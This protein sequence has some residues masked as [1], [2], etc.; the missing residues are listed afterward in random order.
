MELLYLLQFQVITWQ[1]LQGCCRNYLLQELVC[2]RFCVGVLLNNVRFIYSF[3]NVMFDSTD[4]NKHVNGAGTKDGE[5]ANE[6]VD[7]W[8]AHKTDTGVVYYYN[9]LTGESTYE[10]PSDF[11]GEV[12]NIFIFFNK[13]I[14][15][16]CIAR[17]FL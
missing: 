14:T 10:K 13:L 5:A 4:D 8:T 12:P 9:A 2:L 6:Q 3:T 16:L 7:A 1:I 11:K 15:M 17:I